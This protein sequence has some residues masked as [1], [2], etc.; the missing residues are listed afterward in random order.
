MMQQSKYLVKK[1][2][3]TVTISV[4]KSKTKP[5]KESFADLIQTFFWD[6]WD[7]YFSMGRLNSLI[8]S[9]CRDDVSF[10][11]VRDAI[12]T[13]SLKDQERLF[14]LKPVVDQIKEQLPLMAIDWECTIMFRS[15]TKTDIQNFVDRANVLFDV[16]ILW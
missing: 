9:Y 1:F 12:L 10:D 2:P 3:T 8:Q 6:N 15:I 14:A 16:L 13:L 7:L 5:I 11:H 4:D